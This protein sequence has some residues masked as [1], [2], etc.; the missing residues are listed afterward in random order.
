MKIIDLLKSRFI[1]H[2]P[3]RLMH[4]V[5]YR[6]NCTCSMYNKWNY[7]HKKKVQIN[8]NKWGLRSF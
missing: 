8:K 2:S 7:H 4:D 3:V 5:T 1:T 6:C